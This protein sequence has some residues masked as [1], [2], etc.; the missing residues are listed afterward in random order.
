MI[1]GVDP[2]ADV[3]KPGGVGL[4]VDGSPWWWPLAD[5][6]IRLD[7]LEVIKGFGVRVAY[8][9]AVPVV[10]G[11]SSP[12]SLIRQAEAAGEMAGLFKGLGW[13]VRRPMPTAWQA[14]AGLPKSKSGKME[15]SARDRLSRLRLGQIAPGVDWAGV[16]SG[17]LDGLLISWAAQ[18]L[19]GRP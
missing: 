5:G 8:V 1:L 12:S 7:D 9:E 4:W 13:R 10:H 6:R 2:G 11:R 16:P 17:C 15:K 19:D 18:R 14:A 3:R